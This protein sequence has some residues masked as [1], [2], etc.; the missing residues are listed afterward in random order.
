ML[1]LQMLACKNACAF[2][3][4]G[5]TIDSTRGPFVVLDY[6]NGILLQSQVDVE[7]LKAAAWRAWTESATFARVLSPLFYSLARIFASLIGLTVVAFPLGAVQSEAK[8]CRRRPLS[9]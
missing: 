5:K 7:P 9:C 4:E 8:P 2:L 3:F 6:V 1:L